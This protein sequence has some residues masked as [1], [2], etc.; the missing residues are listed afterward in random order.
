[1]EKNVVEP[2]RLQMAIRRL[3]LA[4]WMSK[5]YRRL[6]R[7][8]NI[9]FFSTAAIVT[10]MRLNDTLYLHVICVSCHFIIHVDFG[11]AY[12]SGTLLFCGPGSS[13]GTATD[14]GLDDPGIEL[15]RGP[16]FPS[17]QTGPGAYP[18]SCT[19]GTG[20][21]SGVKCGWGVTL[22]TH[23]LLAPRS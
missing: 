8:W 4:C 5:G 23:P 13:V 18:A 22:T 2:C 11:K 1:M 14:Y 21:F 9:Y 10:L 19:M 12:R 6:L 20:S 3:R 17:V 15:R 16:D 7:I